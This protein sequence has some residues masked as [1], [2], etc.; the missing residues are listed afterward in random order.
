[1]WSKNGARL[2]KSVLAGMLIASVH[3]ALG[4]RLS[5]EI[6]T[7]DTAQ[8]QPPASNLARPDLRLHYRVV[9]DKGPYVIMLAGG[10][11][12]S[13]SMMRPICDHL[14][15]RFRCVMLEQRGTDRSMPSEYNS[16]TLNF[17]AYLADIE[18]LRLHLG[19]DR[20]ILVGNSWG[21]TLAFAYAGSFPER[22]QALA[23]LGSGGLTVDQFKRFRDNRQVRISAAQDEDIAAVHRQNLPMDQAVTQIA[24]ILMPNYFFNRE[25]ALLAAAS[26]QVGDINYRLGE[27]TDAILARSD[28][29]AF[30]RL[31]RIT[32]PVLMVQGRQDLAP[33]E[34]ARDV[35]D[36]VPDAEV[37]LLDECGHIPWLDQPTAT[38]RAL[39]GFLNEHV[40]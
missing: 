12:G 13:V 16:K 2:I 18:A 34:V 1:M 8:P 26:V 19:Q 28:E 7:T 22:V 4:A 37:L 38:W 31:D 40:G 17:E 3:T 20:L 21:M 9:G 14:K 35:E 15:D 11:G 10:P 33:E 27:H 25:A 24:K 6:L 39:D 36:R 23:T 5:S 29:L 32:A 30:G